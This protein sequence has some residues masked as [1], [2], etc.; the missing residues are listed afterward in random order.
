MKAEDKEV[1]DAEEME[2]KRQ[3]KLTEK[4][5]ESE[6]HRL[7]GVRRGVL[8]LLTSK[9]KEVDSLLAICKKCNG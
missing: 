1:M 3:I 4:A 8:A 2:P 5:S 7:T 9:K 6:L